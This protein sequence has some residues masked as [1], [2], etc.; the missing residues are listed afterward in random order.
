M[1]SIFLYLFIYIGAV[2]AL[3]SCS[4]ELDPSDVYLYESVAIVYWMGDNGL[5][6]YAD[7]DIKE[8]VAGK[9]DIPENCKIIIYADLANTLP[10]IYELDAKEGKK[11]WKQFTEEE[12]CTDSATILTNLKDIVRAFPARKYGLT[13]GSHG[14]GMELR[15]RKALGPDQSHYDKWLDIPTLRGVLEQLPHMSY[16]FF[17]VC[18][19]QSIEVAYEL[20]KQTDWIIGSPAEIPSIGAPYHL[21]TKAL[22]E[23]D[24]SSIVKEYDGYF[25]IGNFQGTLLSVIKCNELESFA[26]A[27]NPYIKN[28]FADRQTITSVQADE[29]QKYSSQF[30]L[31]TYGYDINSAMFHILSDEEYNNWVK[32]FE[33]AVPIH[34]YNTGRWTSSWYY[35]E[36]IC[37]NPTIYDPDHFGGVTMYIPEEGIEGDIKNDD[38]KHYQWFKDAGWNRTGW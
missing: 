34:K 28:A 25:P 11:V 32:A 17:D 20:R 7:A 4:D 31:Y 36:R 30:A 5:S 19:M 8:L 10:V 6:S 21:L 29:I 3:S 33:K 38:L 26:A 16:I 12:D 1:K 37:N 13:F 15:R 18:F 35:V 22:C 23:G 14:T 27:T 9:D 2:F 24:V